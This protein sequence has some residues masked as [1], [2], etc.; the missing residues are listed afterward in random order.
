MLP[1]HLE[2]L[3]ELQSNRFKRIFS[4]NEKDIPDEM[5]P[6]KETSQQDDWGA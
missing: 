4:S 3:A 5:L 6:Q 2:E 1:N